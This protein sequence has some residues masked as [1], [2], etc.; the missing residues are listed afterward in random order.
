MTSEESSD[1][2]EDTEIEW[3]PLTGLRFVRRHPVLGEDPVHGGWWPYTKDLTDE[4]E[5]LLQA[6]FAS[7]YEVRRVMYGMR[8]WDPAPRQMVLDGRVVRLVGY[9]SQQGASIVLIDASGAKHLDLLVIAPEEDAT[10][11]KNAMDL[12]SLDG[13]QHR[14]AEI[15]E[16]AR[17]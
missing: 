10:V 13:S 11:A 8:G 3:P 6:L 16:L 12:A 1:S 5:P 17:A 15:L 2:V 9:Y 4:L 7:G 14:V